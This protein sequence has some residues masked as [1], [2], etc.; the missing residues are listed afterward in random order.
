MQVAREAFKN[1]S[2]TGRAN[3]LADNEQ[4]RS[5]VLPRLNKLSLKLVIERQTARS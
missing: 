1:A 2:E 5:V 4:A 3:A